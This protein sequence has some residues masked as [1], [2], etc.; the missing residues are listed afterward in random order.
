MVD[1]ARL[2]A[3]TPE[4][5][6]A[7][8]DRANA[9]FRERMQATIQ[10]RSD[11]ISKVMEA[12]DRLSPEALQFAESLSRMARERDVVSG[13]NGG[14]LLDLTA[15]QLSFL[16]SLVERVSSPAARQPEPGSRAARFG[17]PRG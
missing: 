9:E 4:E 2:M 6:A 16:D 3:G 5:R 8:L 13:V 17:S 14:R 1:F 7:D 10:R 15:R 12:R 11:A